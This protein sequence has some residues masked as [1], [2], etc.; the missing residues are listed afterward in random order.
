MNFL[1]IVKED[2]SSIYKNRFLRFAV[3]GIV[4]VPLLYSL[5]YLAAFWDPYSRMDKLPVAIVNLDKGATMDGDEVNYGQNVC[6]ELKDNKDMGW[7]FVGYEDA[8]DGVNGDKYYSMFVIPE[9]FSENVTS[10]KADTPVKADIIYT[11]NNKKN[12]LASQIGGKVEDKLKEQITQTI[13]KEYAKVTFEQFDTVKDGMNKA[14]DGSK[15]IADGMSTLKDNIPTLEDGVGKLYDGSKQLN[16]GIGVLNSKVSTINPTELVKVSRYL[17]DDT[18][19]KLKGAISVANKFQ[20]MDLSDLDKIN[21]ETVSLIE[22]SYT[23]IQSLGNSKGLNLIMSEPSIQN[24]AE[25][26]NPSN[27]QGIISLQQKM[28]GL[29]VL[30]DDANV[31][32]AQITALE[33]QVPK[34]L[35]NQDLQTQIV[36]LKQA[37]ASVNTLSEASKLISKEDTQMLLG[38][39]NDPSSIV[40]TLGDVNTKLQGINKLYESLSPTD[41]DA[42][43]KQQQFQQGFGAVVLKMQTA[44]K[45]GQSVE[46]TP[47]ETGLVLT[48]INNMNQLTEALKGYKPTFDKLNTDVAKYSKVINSKLTL[49]QAN[50]QSVEALKSLLTNYDSTMALI[51]NEKPLLNSIDKLITPENM[52]NL[53]GVMTTV[54]KLKVDLNNNEQ[55]IN[56]LTTLASG[57]S[58]TMSNKDV[59]ALIPQLQSIQNDLNSA[60]PLLNGLNTDKMTSLLND[61]PKYVAM[62][63]TVQ[64]DVKN[65]QDLLNK[66]NNALTSG[67]VNKAKELINSVPTLTGGVKQ[68]YEGSSQLTNGLGQLQG[69]IPEL[70]DG[71]VKLSDGSNELS[72]SLKDGAD[73]LDDNLVN[74]PEEMGTFISEPVVMDNKII[75]E[76]KNYGTGFAPYFIPLSLWVGALMMFFVISPKSK[77]EREGKD[78]SS[79]SVVLG[80]FVIYGVVGVIQAVLASLVVLGLG[81]NPSNLPMYFFFNILMSLTFV[82]MMQF[83]ISTLGDAGRL[84]AIVLL[85]LQLTACAGTFPLEVVPNLFKVLNPYMPFTY[86]VKAL[87][88][89][90]SGTDTSVIVQCSTIFGAILVV[91]VGLSVI[92]RRKGN[93]I[94]SRLEEIKSQ[95]M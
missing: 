23:D 71:V 31:L 49:M 39:L 87:R 76:V 37:I 40:N 16:D 13:S 24:L 36:N 95:A 19:A 66:A 44:A 5:L 60:K 25:Q 65:N 82:A 57:L 14:A 52:K 15:Q 42:Q 34:E 86:A 75:D 48:Y 83:F 3:A 47:Q 12:F 79:T 92:L 84:I 59:Q 18:V 21:P 26:L 91:F 88:E 73:K 30:V 8:V 81:L 68:L 64:N 4:I 77:E 20:N 45:S 62:I 90:I 11:S 72:T 74:T 35:L 29:N 9:N 51:N 17:N 6:D 85:I 80:K 7:R 10:A 46:L 53:Q 41:P 56:E 55:T 89:A 94:Q 43:A 32:K 69:N 70:K 50:P 67:N 61:S 1:K 33:S 58:K 54:N 28:Q 22:K 27:P 93:I 63:K 2:L 38:I 78:V